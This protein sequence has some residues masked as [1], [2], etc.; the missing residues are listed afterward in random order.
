MKPVLAKSLHVILSQ[1]LM[2]LCLFA[3]FQ[4]GEH[5]E[6]GHEHRPHSDEAGSDESDPAARRTYF[7]G[8]FGNVFRAKNLKCLFVY[9]Q[10]G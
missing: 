8:C 3:Y 10:P 9:F 7:L 6:D 1:R 5:E 4:S 2:V